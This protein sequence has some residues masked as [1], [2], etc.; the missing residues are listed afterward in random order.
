MTDVPLD[1]TQTVGPYELLE[2]I[3]KG[4]MGTVWLAQ[5]TVIG[6]RVV[7]KF[8]HPEFARRPEIV[9]RFVTEARASN[10]IDSPDVVQISDFGTAPDGSP[11]LVME[12]L[13]GRSLD[14]FIE[15]TGIVP[16]STARAIGAHIA[17]VLAAA[18]AA[19]IV[20]RDLKPA[21]VFLVPDPGDKTRSRVKLLDFGIAKLMEGAPLNAKVATKT[22]A[23]MGTPAY[24]SPEQGTGEKVDARTD[25][26]ALGI[27]LY[28]ML[29]GT[30]PFKAE[31]F[32]ALI[33]EHVSM[34]PPSLRRM[35]P[36]IS[37]DAE[38]IVLRC[39]AKRPDARFQTMTELMEALAAG[40]AA[41]AIPAD[42]SISGPFSA[43]AAAGG[44]A[45]LPA[46][47]SRDPS[48]ATPT[49]QAKPTTLRSSA[50]EL[51]HPA[52]QPAP[53][54]R[55]L[56]TLLVA[57]GG[58][59]VLLAATI[60]VLLFSGALDSPEADDRAPKIVTEAAP[61]EPAHK[62]PAALAAAP[63]RPAEEEPKPPPATAP[64]AAAPAPTSAPT[65]ASSPDARP[66]VVLRIESVPSRATVE[67]PATGD[68]L[69]ETPYELEL[70]V[71]APRPTLRLVRPGYR[72]E[73][74]S[75]PTDRS[76]TTLVRLR[77]GFGGASTK[78]PASSRSGTAVDHGVD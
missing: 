11:Y 63:D 15:A 10:A 76:H 56:T 38:R 16:E 33:T 66:R 14:K 52:A 18:H 72:P 45:S 6:R 68:R 4:G 61:D 69:G 74:I 21:N 1:A 32:G 8:L 57:A 73:T 77:K 78:P 53:A 30:V 22:G 24:M 27:I 41:P 29:C 7:I 23:V 26:Y 67:D 35:D 44:A 3:G 37:A 46:S 49:L 47:F 62:R 60:L 34:P 42:T 64:A 40:P 31:N 13:R 20:H 5:H 25:V 2:Q 28:E 71:G 65:I 50:A 59:G 70:P 36:R 39:L 75:P 17:T 55:R 19:G 12:H 43:R 51:S 48:P 54:R 9:H 58:A